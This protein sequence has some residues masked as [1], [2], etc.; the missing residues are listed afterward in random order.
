MIPRRGFL[1]AGAAFAAFPYRAAADSSHANVVGKAIDLRGSMEQGS[2]VVGTAGPGTSVSIDKKPVRVT[3]EGAFAFGF[4]YDQTKGVDIVARSASGLEIVQVADP[5]VRHYDVQKINGLPQKF[6]TP[7]K[8]VL[9]R[10]ARENA[11]VGEARKRDSDATAF[12]QPFDWPAKGILSG[13]FGSQRIDNGKAMAPHFG[14]DI[15]APEG[16]P[17]HAPADGTVTLAEPDF[18]LTGGTTLL[19]HGHGVSTT[20]IHQSALK[21]KV[22]DA[23]KRGDLIGLVGKK[24]RATGPHLHWAMNW[25]QIRLDPSRSTAVAAPEKS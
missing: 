25:F 4:S 6:V 13:T 23:V 17:I 16:A 2:L 3:P 1:A 18:Y 20:Y 9:E 21:V 7:P 14:V 10:I 12:A 22:G 24:G 11:L 19:D 8:D 15:A 5:V